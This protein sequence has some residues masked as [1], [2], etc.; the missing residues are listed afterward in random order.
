MISASTERPAST[1]VHA[2]WWTWAVAGLVTIGVG[3][4]VMFKPGQSLKALAVIA[5]IY[6][7]FDAVVALIGALRD[8]EG[9]P[10][11]VLHGVLG[12]VVGLLLVRHPLQSVEAI[13]LLIG[14]WLLAVGSVGFVAGFQLRQHRVWHMAVALIQ[15]LAGIV[16]VANPTIGYSALALIAGIALILQG[17]GML[18]LAWSLRHA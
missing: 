5:G 12:L 18:V 7:L 11:A 13:A 1:T 17:L 9:R 6:F 8:E 14:I 2:Y 16:I 15:L 10:M 4:V 3:V